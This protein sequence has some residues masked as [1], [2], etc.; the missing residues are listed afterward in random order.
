[1]TSNFVDEQVAA[2]SAQR[3]D[4]SFYTCPAPTPNTFNTFAC[5][6]SLTSSCYHKLFLYT[7]MSCAD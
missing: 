1:M 3:I 6:T 2:P 4:E 7:E 5:L